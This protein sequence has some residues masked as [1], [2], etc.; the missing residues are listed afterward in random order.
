MKWNYR[1]A[2][3]MSNDCYE[4]IEVYYDKDGKP[5]RWI[6]AGLEEWASKDNLESTLKLMLEA[7][8]KPNIVLRSDGTL[9]EGGM[10][11]FEVELTTRAVVAAESIHDAYSIAESN[12][13]EIV[14]D[15]YDIDVVN[16]LVKGCVLPTGWNIESYT[17]LDSDKNIGQIWEEQ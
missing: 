2:E 8:Q 9:E 1:V 13:K 17:Y 5:E 10:K 11:L 4:I 3:N 16:E 14:G 15:D 6:H 12:R 7:F